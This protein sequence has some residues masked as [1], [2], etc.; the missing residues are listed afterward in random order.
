[1]TVRFFHIIL[2]CHLFCA[3][4]VSVFWVKPY[5]IFVLLWA[6]LVDHSPALLT[7]PAI[8]VVIVIAIGIVIIDVAIVVGIVIMRV[9]SWVVLKSFP[10]A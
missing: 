7:R 10:V 3:P 5:D 9:S 8:A 6:H 1:M 2:L 4:R